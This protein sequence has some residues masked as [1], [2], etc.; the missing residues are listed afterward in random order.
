[1]TF[2]GIVPPS[3]G[4]DSKKASL[5]LLMQRKR[6]FFAYVHNKD[7]ECQ[8]DGPLPA[9]PHSNPSGLWC[10]TRCGIL[11]LGVRSANRLQTTVCAKRGIASTGSPFAGDPFELLDLPGVLF[12]DRNDAVLPLEGNGRLNVL[13]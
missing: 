5:E 7:I 8:L 2:L 12:V 1:M 9:Y 13:L 6:L 3:K 4:M 11:T 10:V